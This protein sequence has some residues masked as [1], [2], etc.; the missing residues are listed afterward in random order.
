[1][2]IKAFLHKQQALLPAESTTLDFA[3]ILTSLLMT[4]MLY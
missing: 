2:P 1:M 4:E 3:V